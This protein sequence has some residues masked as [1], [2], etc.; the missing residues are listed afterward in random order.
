MFHTRSFFSF[1]LVTLLA[2][3]CTSAYV[4]APLPT[5]HPANPAAPEAPPPSSQALTG[6]TLPP[7]PIEQMPAPNPHAGHSTMH[8]GH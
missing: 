3:G 2:S 4:P 7:A 8:G 1:V 5:T 6:E